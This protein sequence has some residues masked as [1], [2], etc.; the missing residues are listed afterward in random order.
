L[1][2]TIPVKEV[3]RLVDVS[4]EPLDPITLVR[5]GIPLQALYQLLLLRKQRCR[6]PR[7]QGAASV[8]NSVPIYQ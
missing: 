8:N 1:P 3:E 5:P 2:G 4:Q 6:R 7:L